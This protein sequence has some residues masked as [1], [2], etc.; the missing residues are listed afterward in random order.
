MEINFSSR[1]CNVKIVYYGPGLSGKT[2][3]LEVIHAR[4]PEDNRGNLTALA[5]DQDRTLFFDYMPLEIGEISGLKIRLRLFTVPGQV[6]YNSTRKLVLRCVDGVV[7]IADSQ[8]HKKEENV[9]S[10]ENL[11]TNLEE[12]G[13]DLRNLPFVIQFNKRD[14][15]NVMTLEE[16]EE[17]LNGPYK[18][19]CFPAVAMKGDG[20]FQCLKSIAN[21]SI[22]KVEENIK[23]RSRGKKPQ[24]QKIGNTPPMGANPRKPTGPLPFIPPKKREQ[25]AQ[26][27]FSTGPGM[28]RPD[29]LLEEQLHLLE[30]KGLLD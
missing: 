24:R 27:T 12:H 1:E 19:P 30:K 22:A 29:S 3:N 14:L 25:E 23:N 6:Y 4:T 21:L 20:V 28:K 5:T 9:E 18:A 17:L 13:L 11:R 2:T 26:R 8:I 16:M 7:F 10:L 15:P